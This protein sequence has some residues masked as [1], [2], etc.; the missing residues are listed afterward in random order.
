MS[1]QEIQEKEARLIEKLRACPPVLVGKHRD[2]PI[3]MFNRHQIGM[4]VVTEMEHTPD[5][6]QAKEIAKDHLSEIPDYYDR[7]NAM[8][9]QAKMEGKFHG[10]D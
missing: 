6:C 4:G 3:E 1:E 10:T 8:E 5:P 9:D 2:V 7:L